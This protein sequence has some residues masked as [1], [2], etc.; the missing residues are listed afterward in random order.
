M[1][2][3]QIAAALLFCAAASALQAQTKITWWHAMGGRLG[4]KV[5]A[6]AEG[7]NKSQSSYILV[8]VNKGNYTETMTAGIAA[9][10]AGKPPNI[11]QVFEVGTATM[12]SAKGA[13]KP[14]YKLMAET[15]APFDPDAYLP[16]VTG[17][18]TTTDG[19]LLSMPFN[20]STPILYYN[21]EAFKKAGLPD[22]APSTWPELV[23]F[24]QKTQRAG[25]PCGF[26]TAW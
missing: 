3:L 5:K 12:M 18:Y 2:V 11:I 13:I 6:I 15:G 23:E 7:F 8:P 25:Y 22:R 20:S 17:Y 4:E 14:V 24:A 10:R 26:T 9:F 16:T 19:K 21:K 1:L